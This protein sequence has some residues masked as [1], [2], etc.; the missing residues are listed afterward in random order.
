MPQLHGARLGQAARVEVL[1][2]AVAQMRIGA[3]DAGRAVLVDPLSLVGV[4]ALAPLA[5]RIA[6]VGQPLVSITLLLPRRDD[7]REHSGCSR[8]EQLNVIVL[9]E[10]TVGEPLLGHPG[11]RSWCCACMGSIWFM[12]L[13][14]LMSSTPVMIIVPVSTASCALNAGREP[15]SG[16]FITRASRSVVLTRGSLGGLG[17]LGSLDG[18]SAVCS[19]SD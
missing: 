10:S 15:P 8:V 6:V 1:Q 4:H 18:Y 9:C 14:E 2:A 13:P 7:R 11:K 19:A 17:G 5:Q 12:S 16:I 3:V